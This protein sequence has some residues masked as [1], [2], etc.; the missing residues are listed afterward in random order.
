[1]TR[2]GITVY[3]VSKLKKA[4]EELEEKGFGDR[5]VLVPDNDIDTENDYRTISS[6]DT[7]DMANNC[8]YL[9][10]FDNEDEETFWEGFDLDD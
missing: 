4:L 3:T 10:T 8:I 2:N 7:D 1:M 5:I 6:I 9:E